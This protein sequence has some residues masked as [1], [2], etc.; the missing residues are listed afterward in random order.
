MAAQGKKHGRGRAPV[1]EDDDARLLDLSDGRL[2]HDRDAVRAELGLTTD[3]DAQTARDR[4]A[5]RLGTV[6]T[7]GRDED[8]TRMIEVDIVDV[9]LLDTGSPGAGAD[10]RRDE[11]E[12]VV[13]LLRMEAGDFLKRPDADADAAFVDLVHFVALSSDSELGSW[14]GAQLTS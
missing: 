14:V 7:I 6:V 1:T 13:S 3:A 12:G 9:E 4:L 11:I 2:I 8:G 10:G 5:A